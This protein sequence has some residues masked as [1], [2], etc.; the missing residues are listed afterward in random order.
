M[1]KFVCIFTNILIFILKTQTVIILGNWYI[2]KLNII[3]TQWMLLILRIVD[4][5]ISIVGK[6]S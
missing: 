5:E 3:K 1:K 6:S 4:N 2:S